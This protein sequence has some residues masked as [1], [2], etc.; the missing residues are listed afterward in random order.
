ML[1]IPLDHTVDM[2]KTAVTAEGTVMTTLIIDYEHAFMT[3]PLSSGEQTFNCC[4]VVQDLSM[5][6]EYVYANTPTTGK[7]IVWRVLG[8]GGRPTPLL[9]V[10]AVSL[11]MRYAQ[12][13]GEALCDNTGT[14][15]SQLY[16][17]GPT[18]T[19][20]G[21]PTTVQHTFDGL[22]LVWL[23]IGLPLTWTGVNFLNNLDP[24]QKCVTNTKIQLPFAVGMMAVFIA[25][26]CMMAKRRNR[27]SDN[28]KLIHEHK[29]PEHIPTYTR[30]I[31]HDLSS[32]TKN[33][34]TDDSKKIEFIKDLEN[35]GFL[36]R[37][38]NLGN[39][40]LFCGSG[41]FA[42][43]FRVEVNGKQCVVKCLKEGGACLLFSIIRLLI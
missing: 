3:I 7:F 40:L 36:I 42:D 26:V 20:T 1:P 13:M 21:S 17:C 24:N 9:F 6:R 28:S 19:V 34:I 10:R 15:K 16:V 27:G 12:C 5:T 31:K 41:N 33:A 23:I 35:R 30:S 18:I 39:K 4:E 38:R 11:A 43:V 2:A 37:N 25:L 14:F 29:K 32:T 8:L 22:L